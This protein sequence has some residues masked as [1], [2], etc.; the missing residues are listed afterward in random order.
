MTKRERLCHEQKSHC[1][2]QVCSSGEPWITLFSL[3][4]ALNT[5]L[6]AWALREKVGSELRQ[7]SVITPLELIW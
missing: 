7:V 1:S 4:Y 6:T 5:R 3:S 2:G